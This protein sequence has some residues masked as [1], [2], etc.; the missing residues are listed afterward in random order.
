MSA[1]PSQSA[2]TTVNVNVPSGQAWTVSAFPASQKSGWLT[3]F[4][5]SGTGPATVNLVAAAPGLANGVYTTTLV[6]QSANTTPQFVNVPVTFTIGASS[7]ISI[8]GVAHGASYQHVYAP[9]MLVSVFGTNLAASDPTGI[10]SP[11]AADHG[12]SFG[13]GQW[14]CRPSPLRF[15]GATEHPDPLRDRDRNGSPGRQQQRAGGYL[16]VHGI[17]IGSG[18]VYPEPAGHRADHRH[19]QRRPGTTI[20][21]LRHRSGRGVAAHRH[22]GGAYRDPGARAASSGLR[23]GRRRC[24]ELWTMSASPV[25]RWEPFRSTSRCRRTLPWARNRWWSRWARPPARRRSTF[26]VQ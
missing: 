16:L 5:L 17:G 10:H 23:D 7:A 11:P 3:V 18:A 19:L 6:F 8:G 12:R 4:P 22:R 14:D 15:A 26:T 2:A 13:Y 25:G 24:G 20:H 21:A 9:G 1:S